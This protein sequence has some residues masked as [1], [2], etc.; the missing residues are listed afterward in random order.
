[1]EYRSVLYAKY[2]EN[3]ILEDL[4][5]YDNNMDGVKPLLRT[6]IQ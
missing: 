4:R 5:K 3:L 6:P 2:E 1:M